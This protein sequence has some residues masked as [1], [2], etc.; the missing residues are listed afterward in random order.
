MWKEDAVSIIPEK[1]KDE[2]P[3]NAKNCGRVGK[4]LMG[5]GWEETTE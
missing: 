2:D 1:I 3:G 4:Y 5:V